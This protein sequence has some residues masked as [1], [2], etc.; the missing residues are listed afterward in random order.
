MFSCFV[1]IKQMMKMFEK[2]KIDHHI[3]VTL[4]VLDS[5]CK[6]M[7]MFYV[8]KRIHVNVNEN[9]QPNLQQNTYAK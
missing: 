1:F 7:L 8:T 9:Q 5:L 3:F 6:L 4:S 2:V